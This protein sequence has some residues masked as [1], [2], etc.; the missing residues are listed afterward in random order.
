MAV[1]ASPNAEWMN[2]Q[3]EMIEQLS[4]STHKFKP[5]LD[6]LEGHSEDY[7][8]VGDGVFQADIVDIRINENRYRVFLSHALDTCFLILLAC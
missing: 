2:S 1:A 4:V 7:E 6:F 5:A 3:M 8:T